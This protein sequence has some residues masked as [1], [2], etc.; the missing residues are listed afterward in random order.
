MI[1][2]STAAALTFDMEPVCTLIHEFTSRTATTQF[3]MQE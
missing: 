2:S 1:T 3:K